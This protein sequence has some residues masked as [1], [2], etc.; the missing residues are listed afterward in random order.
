L[1]KEPNARDDTIRYFFDNGLVLLNI[2][3]FDGSF[4]LCQEI[5]KALNCAWIE[6]RIQEGNHW[7]YDLFLGDI[8][9]DRFSADPDYFDP[10][11]DDKEELK[12]KP[13]LVAKSF[14]IDIGR[15]EKYI[16]WWGPI[17]E[18]INEEIIHQ[19]N[20]E[21]GNIKI[22]SRSLDDI[23]KTPKRRLSGK[24]YEYDEFEYGDC[25]QMADFMKALGYT[26]DTHDN[27]DARGIVSI[28]RNKNTF[29]RR[30]KSF[31]GL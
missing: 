30:I 10:E 25:W 11:R 24:A 3:D 12:G 2:N 28:S 29:W 20:T 14:N 7:E 4:R 18:P 15:I 13:K 21:L 31:F 26:R 23:L 6:L 19:V 1:E 5:G 9:I 16:Q 22:V 17:I 8:N 27:Y